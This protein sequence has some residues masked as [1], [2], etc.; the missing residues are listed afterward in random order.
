[1]FDQNVG[2]VGLSFISAK[3]AGFACKAVWGSFIDKPDYYPE[4]ESMMLKMVYDSKTMQ[5]LGLQAVGKG[6]ICRRIDTFSSFL[7]NNANVSDLINF[8]HGYAPPYAEALDPLHH[9]AGVAIAQEKGMDFI[10]PGQEI[11]R[12]PDPIW[13]DVREIE[14]AKEAPIIK[15]EEVINIPIGELRKLLDKF[16][17]KR[18]IIVICRRGPRSYQAALILKAAGFDKVHV[19]A[20]GTSGIV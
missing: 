14:E 1:V 18:N 13:L 5:L 11:D 2:S 19:Y 17:Q 16:D 3:K 8:E 15:D 4:S 9:L 10:G 12:I 7:Q 6:D 20:G